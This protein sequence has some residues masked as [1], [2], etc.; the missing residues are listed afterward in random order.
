MSSLGAAATAP[1][2]RGPSVVDTAVDSLQSC[3]YETNDLL[4]LL[5]RR[6]KSV[7][8]AA[9]PAGDEAKVVEDLSE[10]ELPKQLQSAIYRQQQLNQRLHDLITRLAVG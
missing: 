10:A 5:E 6:L 9:P 8:R 1:A 4:G 7:L 2:E 3:Q